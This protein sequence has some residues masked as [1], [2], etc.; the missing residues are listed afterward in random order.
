MDEERKTEKLIFLTRR[1]REKE[2][3]RTDRCKAWTKE[4]EIEKVGF[5]VTLCLQ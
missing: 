3:R 5:K 4:K 2:K 1:E